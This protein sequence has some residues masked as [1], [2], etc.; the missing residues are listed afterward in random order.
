MKLYKITDAEDKTYGGCMWGEG[1]TVA[2]S[3]EGQMCGS[4]FTH[5]YK[6]PLLA[7]FLNKIHA[8]F[9]LKTAHLWEGEGEIIKDD[10]MKI[11]CTKATT[12]KRVC[13]PEVNDIQRVAFGILCAR[14][15]CKDKFFESWSRN[16]LSGKDRSAE[17]A[18]QAA[19]EAW[20]YDASAA[21]RSAARSAAAAAEF[22]AEAAASPAAEFAAEAA[23]SAAMDIHFD[24]QTVAKK[25]MRY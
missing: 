19:T 14:K 24:L 5:W 2:T 23:R 8:N 13:L 11:G 20:A 18:D 25:A 15:V 4:G 22:A 7:V 3:G 21:A 17:A 6:S 1:I 9:D 16:W 12:I 10:G